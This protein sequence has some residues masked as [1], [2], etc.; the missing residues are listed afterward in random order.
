LVAAFFFATFFSSAKTETWS[1]G[2]VDDN[3]H[4]LT[5]PHLRNQENHHP[6]L[7]LRGGHRFVRSM[8]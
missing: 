7:D 2:I 3:S 6:N 1:W 5:S 8:R 4:M